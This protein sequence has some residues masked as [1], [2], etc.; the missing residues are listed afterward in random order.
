M[1]GPVVAAGVA[2]QAS[3]GGREADCVDVVL[4]DAVLHVGE[5]VLAQRLLQEE[6]DQWGL[7]GLVA[8]FTQ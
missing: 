2:K 1:G 7:E 6:A 8:Q 4:Q 5:G 3:A